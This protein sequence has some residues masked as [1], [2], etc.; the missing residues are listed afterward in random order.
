VQQTGYSH[1][2]MMFMTAITAKPT[3]H[4]INRLKIVLTE[5]NPLCPTLSHNPGGEGR[6]RMDASGFSLIE[7][8]ITITLLGIIAVSLHQ[9][10]GTSL[11]SSYEIE[12]KQNI[13]TNVSFA[14][15]RMAMFVEETDEVSMPTTLLQ[16]E[17][18]VTERLL[19]TYDNSSH[20]YM[21][22][23]DGFLDADHDRNGFINEEVSD[24]KE[25]IRFHLDKTDPTNWKLMETKPAYNTS[26]VGDSAAP[27]VLC[28]HVTVFQCSRLSAKLIEIQLL[29][30][31]DRTLGFRFTIGPTTEIYVDD[32]YTDTEAAVRLLELQ[33]LKNL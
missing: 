3:Q 12:G 11:S 27:K 16:E 31:R 8:L 26:A 29:S 30:E 9:I 23:G 28:E 32:N 4:I 22:E 7:L 2:A 21:I 1:N 18:I 33:N 15:E 25:Y 10:V 17:L 14:M 13:L 6:V 5:S 20:I 24:P 19:D